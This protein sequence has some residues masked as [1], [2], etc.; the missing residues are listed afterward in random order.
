MLRIRTLGAPYW[1]IGPE[2]GMAQHEN[3]DLKLRVEAWLRFGGPELCD[4]HAFHGR[5]GQKQWHQ[6][7]PRL[8]STWRPFMLLLMTLLGKRADNDSLRA[9]QRDRWG[10][11]SGGE[12]CVIELSGLAANNSTVLRERDL[13]RRERIEVIRQRILVYKPA[14]VVM[15]GVNEKDH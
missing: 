3:D 14:L 10:R 7:T 5:I 9:Y 11:L 6:D 2:Q 13:F 12:T 8:Q 1:F 4:C 15:Y